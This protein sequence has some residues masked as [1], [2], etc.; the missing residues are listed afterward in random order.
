[1]KQLRHAVLVPCVGL[2]AAC[3]GGAPQE[4]VPVFQDPALESL[5]SKVN[6]LIGYSN[7]EQLQQQ[8]LEID[9]PAFTAGTRA[10]LHGE[11]SRFSQEEAQQA[12][13]EFRDQMQQE[14]AAEF[15]RLSE[16]N[17]TQ[18]DAFLTENGA[19]EDV[20]TTESGLQYRVLEDAEGAKPAADSRVQ[21]HYEGRLINGEVFDSSIARGEP[22]E[23]SLN[24]VIAGWTEGLQLMPEGAKFEFYVPPELAYGASGTGGGI[25]PNEALI[26]VVELLQAHVASE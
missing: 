15:A 24:E 13:A 4:E 22:V 17:L 14:A 2:I 11:P 21:V 23:F 10:A 3:G 1:M 16:E 26:F 5:E 25:G 18:S 7:V 19:R 9:V 20:I 6:Y 12:F 8:G